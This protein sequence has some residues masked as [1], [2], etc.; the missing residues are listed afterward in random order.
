MY[1]CSDMECK[2][3]RFREIHS[4][5]CGFDIVVNKDGQFIEQYE[6]NVHSSNLEMIECVM[7]CSKAEWI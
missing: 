2:S 1:K 6:H 5:T 7:C 4:S 3:D